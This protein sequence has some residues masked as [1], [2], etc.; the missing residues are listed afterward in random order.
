M[1]NLRKIQNNRDQ[2]SDFEALA[3]QGYFIGKKIG[4]G[5]YAT[6]RLARYY[7]KNKVQSILACKIVDKTSTPT[8]FLKNFFQRELDIIRHLNHPSII[9]IH[10]LLQ[11]G[12]KIFIFMRYAENGD[13]FNYVNNAGPIPEN[14]CKIWTQQLVN[15]LKYLHKQ[16]IAHRDLKC[17]NI[18]L[19]KNLN[20]KLADFGFAK[21]CEGKH[22]ISRTYCG[23]AMYACPE[24]ISGRAYNPK[25]ADIWSLGVVLFII[26]NATMPFDDQNMSKLVLDQQTQNFHFSKA[27]VNSLSEEYKQLVHRI[28]DP[29]VKTRCSLKEIENSDWMNLYN[30]N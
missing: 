12:E 15:G 8:V 26:A 17:E 16:N 27:V 14:Q 11:C 23:S 20:T 24:I 28:L 9:Q 10:S 25:L 21:L 18:L 5:T 4:K 29:N 1:E 30:L 6:V 19:T 22:K 7:D 13:L 2:I 3:I